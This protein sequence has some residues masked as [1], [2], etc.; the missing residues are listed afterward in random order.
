MYLDLVGDDEDWSDDEDFYSEDSF[1]N[2][3][4]IAT[5][6]KSPKQ[7]L[8]NCDICKKEYVQSQFEAHLNGKKHIN[9]LYEI[10]VQKERKD[11]LAQEKQIRVLFNCL[12]IPR[13]LGKVNHFYFME[14]IF[15]YFC[16]DS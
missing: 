14:L 10:R 4:E 16:L 12:S 6:S 11:K 13:I 2:V 9:Q 1:E 5:F 3:D 8:V 7:K 15:S